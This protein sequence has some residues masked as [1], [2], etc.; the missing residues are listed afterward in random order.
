MAS[1]R[2]VAV[3]AGVSTATV[4]R[5]LAGDTPVS[6]GLS[7]RVR[8][9]IADLDYVPNGVARSL[10]RGKTSLLGLLVSDIANPFASQVARG[11]EDEGTRHGYHVLVGSSDF[12]LDRESALLD[13]FTA[14]TVDAVALLSARGGTPAME[15]LIKTSL[16]LVF[17]DS[18]P[19]ADVKAPVI[20]TDNLTAAHDA[21]R[22]LIELGHQDLAMISGPSH[23]PTAYERLL[24]FRTACEEA[25][26]PVRPECIRQGFLGVDG[27]YQAMREVLA[28][29]P[30]PT[31][32]F[33]FNNMLAVG[34]L[35]AVREQQVSVPADLSLVTFDDM[36]LFPYV[37]PPI[38][39]IAQPAYRI[40]VEAG[41]AL[42]GL[43]SGDGP[44]ASE[45]VLASEFRRRASC[46][47][48][49][50]EPLASRGQQHREPP[51]HADLPRHR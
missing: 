17:V 30:V 45:T 18:Q 22:Y 29:E 5:V 14:R 11:L 10:S 28:L 21:V 1:I 51:A 3:R 41:R 36:E 47:P 46:A 32:V 43:L 25:G 31:A 12:D 37:D 8:K 35:R 40:G 33:S 2:D 9:A 50:D 6:D 34:A 49:R 26:L 7:A 38:T 44:A 19:T 48:P 39:A 15:K 13:S 16:P 23:L 27:G 4:A 42:F 24:G 20:R